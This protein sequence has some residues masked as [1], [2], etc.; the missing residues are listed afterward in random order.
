MKKTF[1]ILAILGVVFRFY[2]QF[3]SPYFNVDEISLGSNIKENTFLELLFPM[4]RGQSAPPL[5]LL[6]EKF[7]I[8]FFP[9]SFWVNIKLLSF[10]SSIFIVL[11]LY[12]FVEKYNFSKELLIMFV[13]VL[14][15]PFFLT[16]TL[17]VKQYTFDL[18]GI[19][20][21]IN[22]FNHKWFLKYNIIFF[23]IWSFLS[24]V[25]LF[26][27]VSYLMY[28]YFAI[29]KRLSLYLVLKFIK[30]NFLTILAP[31]PYVFYF[32]WFMN[33]EGAIELKNY[34]TSYW[35]G[36]FMPLNSGIFKF[37]ISLFHSFWVFF[38]S[39]NEVV[40]LLLFLL[41]ISSFLYFKKANKYKAEV[42]IIG[43]TMLIHLLLNIL[44]LYPISDRLFLYMG[45]FFLLLLSSTMNY[46]S[47]INRVS[48]YLNHSEI[49]ISIV[50]FVSYFN[51][52]FYK[53]NDVISLNN[54]LN[55]INC[56]EKIYTT[57]KSFKTIN[58]FNTFTDNKFK[59]KKELIKISSSENFESSFY[60]IT[61]L[62]NKL[63][64]NSTSDEE[65]IISQ[66]RKKYSINKSITLQGYNVYKLNKKK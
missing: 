22:Y 44:H 21:L 4:E 13:I 19:L 26:S 37:I 46:L 58:D 8:S 34:M 62:F 42:V 52:M 28:L 25:A 54:Y 11:L 60:L 10:F 56:S 59:C 7:I 41:S 35:F 5:F 18:L 38:Y 45:M 33:Q 36:N 14:F 9:F 39:M 43:G 6:L 20:F 15:N 55:K 32:I 1:I 51:Y 16:N 30:K 61:R 27:C 2:V 53:E 64:P 40:G 49:I 17:T 66:L 29:N 24:N 23:F 3:I 57:E 50:V 48:K 63:K 12:R 31:L 47:K 65:L